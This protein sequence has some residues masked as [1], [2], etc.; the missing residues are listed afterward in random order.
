MTITSSLPAGVDLDVRLLSGNIGAEIRGVDLKSEL[1][2]DTV[3]ALRT[4][5]LRH[6]VVFFPGQHL[7]PA[8][9]RAFAAYFGSVTP[10]HPVVPG[11][12]DHPEVFE[13][14][15]SKAAQTYATYGDVARKQ[16]LAWHTDVTFV[17]R[18][19]FGSILNAVV[20]PPSGGD[21]LW[22]NQAAAYEGLSTALQRFLDGLTAL[23][24]GKAQFQAVLD[25]VGEG[26][27]DGS[28]VT[29]LQPVE[30]PVVVTHPETGERA[31]FVNPGFTSRIVQLDREES[32]HLLAYL[33][34]HSVRPE[35]TVRYHWTQGDLG[36]WDNRVTQHAVVGDFGS[37]HRVIQRVT[38]QGERPTA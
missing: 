21:T 4:L 10:A 27:W 18:P 35:Y 22:S 26:E 17:E 9:H 29:A 15:Y 1:D 5:L 23:H 25:R 24:D 6:K 3:L 16:G 36:F 8:Q 19:P 7:E 28:A 12:P 37:Q 31:L 13:I 34:A 33:Y 14:D 32:D 30:H 38:L 11:L 20:I 2:A